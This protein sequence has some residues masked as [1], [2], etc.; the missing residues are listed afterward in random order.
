[1]TAP[2][3]TGAV[4]GVWTIQLY[5]TCKDVNPSC[6]TWKEEPG[7]GVE[8]VQGG[9]STRHHMFNVQRSTIDDRH[10]FDYK[11]KQNARPR[12]R[13]VS[14]PVPTFEAVLTGRRGY[15]ASEPSMRST[16]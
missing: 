2:F 4:S 7:L 11:P 12:Y 1:M 9:A 15:V 6:A 3:F 16:Y 13:C 8:H 5:S 14:L 10:T